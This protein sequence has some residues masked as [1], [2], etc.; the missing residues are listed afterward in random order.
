M[1]KAISYYHVQEKQKIKCYFLILIFFNKRKI[2]SQQKN[3]ANLPHPFS[4][5]M[6]DWFQVETL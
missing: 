2:K 3:K 4:L 5:K 1:Q 6:I